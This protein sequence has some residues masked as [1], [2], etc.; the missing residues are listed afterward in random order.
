MSRVTRRHLLQSASV[1]GKVPKYQ[2]PLI[3]PPAMPRTARLVQHGG[4]SVDY[5]EIA[6]RQ[7]QQQ[8]LPT[9]LPSTTVWGYGRSIIPVHSTIRRSLL[10]QR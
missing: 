9:P 8:I 4:K 3:V 5:Y 7:F 1:S 6:V 10:R 2:A